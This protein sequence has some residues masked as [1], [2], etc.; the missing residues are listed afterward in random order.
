MAVGRWEHYLSVVPPDMVLMD[1]S[2]PN[3]PLWEGDFERDLN[4]ASFLP[5]SGRS[6]YT[7]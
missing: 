5:G 3:R 4:H 2:S 7:T 1:F 6:L